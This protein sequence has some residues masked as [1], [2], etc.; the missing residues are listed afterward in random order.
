M[1]VPNPLA[2]RRPPRFVIFAVIVAATALV[3]AACGTVPAP[4]PAKK[5]DD[6]PAVTGKHSGAP[7]D[8]RAGAQAYGRHLLDS[9]RLPPG[10]RVLP[11]GDKPPAGLVP[12]SPAILTDT[13]DLKVIFRVNASM[14]AIKAFLLAHRPVG[15][16]LSTNGYGSRFGTVT[17]RFVGFTPQALPAGIYS[18]DLDYVFEPEPGGGSVLRIDAQVA[19]YPP[20][21]PAEHIDPSR[22]ISVTVS[23][24]TNRATQARTFTSGP[25]LAK[26]AGRVNTLYGAPDVVSH[27]PAIIAGVIN[28]YQLVF[29][30]AR[31]APK[32]VVTPSTAC[33][34]YVDVTVGGRAE[35]SLADGSSLVRVIQ[36]LVPPR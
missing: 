4:G 16:T 5:T 30:P 22:Y 32:I 19:W 3:A 11:W 21:S 23:H 10:A 28:V 35:P 34:E 2:L 12:M 20:R 27:C 17:S 18:A 26:L 9:L 15:L 6:R 13:I 29:V 7:W 1:R 24:R 33:L 14:D 36:R 8:S 25:E 31:G